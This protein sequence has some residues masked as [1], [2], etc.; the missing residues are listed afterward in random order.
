MDTMN[1]MDTMETMDT[2]G[3]M[4]N[5]YPLFQMDNQFKNFHTNACPMYN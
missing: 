1:T 2:L 4:D 5:G 3:T